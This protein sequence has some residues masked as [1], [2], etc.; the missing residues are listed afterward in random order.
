MAENGKSRQLIAKLQSTVGTYVAPTYTTDQDVE[1]YNLDDG[2]NDFGHT[3]G[4]DRSDGTFKKGRSYS[5]QKT[6]TRTFQTDMK[7]S[8]TLATAPKW[9]KFLK[10]CGW[11]VDVSGTNAT[12]TWTGRPVCQ[13]LDFDMPQWNCTDGGGTAFVL[14]SATG[15]FELSWDN[16]GG[17][18]MP[19][20]TFTGKYGGYK[21]VVE[22]DFALPSGY[23]TTACSTFLGA[24]VTFGGQTHNVWAGTLTQGNDNQVVPNSADV[25]NSIKTGVSHVAVK[26]ADVQLSLTVERIA[27]ATYDYESDIIDNTELA[28]VVLA[29]DGF[30]LTCGVAQATDWQGTTNNESGSFDITMKIDTLELKQV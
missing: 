7:P 20:F 14:S 2:T 28:T 22:G 10:G 16:S 18:L 8:G 29:F 11:G 19:S 23:D 17:V 9:W 12:A 5:Q 15:S 6:H 3:G 24:T 26:G 13:T 27:K 4:A 25:T 1:I 21:D 30:E